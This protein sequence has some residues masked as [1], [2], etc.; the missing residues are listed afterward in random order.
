MTRPRVAVLGIFAADVVS[1]V[2]RLPLW[3]ETLLGLGA[4]L[5]PGGKGS[6]QAVAAARLGAEVSF[7]A[8]IGADPFGALAR[9]LYAA[10]GIDTAHLHVDP[11]AP[12]GVALILVGQEGDNAIVVNP[13]AAA[14][15]TAAELDATTPAIRRAGAFLTQLELPVPLAAHAIAAA[16]RAGVPVIFNPAPA[17]PFDRALLAAVDVLTPNET[18]AAALA[19][20]PI[21][22]IESAR[23]AASALRGEGVASVIITLGERGAFLLD[24]EGEADVPAVP[25]PRVVDSTGAGDAF[26][27]ALAVALAERRS[28]RQAVEF[29]SAAA[30]LS[31]QSAGAAPS[32]PARVAVEALLKRASGGGR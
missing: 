21:V 9:D 18:E 1:R 11:E 29:A 24:A 19:G 20:F 23:R 15:L 2:E 7:I 25:V 32:M 13:G 6:N 12:T 14:R 16:R 5:G 3:H 31:V 22:D 27:G 10:E 8:K 17:V 30:A 28:M 26:N 4:S